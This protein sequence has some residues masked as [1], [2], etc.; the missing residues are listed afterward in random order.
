[1]TNDKRELAARYDAATIYFHWLT[2]VLVVGLWVIG[3]TAGW[4][5][6]GPQRATVWSVHVML[7]FAA[8]LVI[9]ARIVWRA[10]FGY[11]PPP[12]NAGLLHV[13]SEAVH[14]L[15]LGLLVTVL[16]TGIATASYRGFNIF[17]VWEVPQFGSGD[18]ATRRSLREW[19]EL[20]AHATMVVAGVHAAA[21]LVHQ[22]VWRDR[23]IDRMR[24]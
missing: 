3:M 7:G 6:R 20:A 4:F 12:A 10:A 17:G 5:P 13:A 19:H 14:Y 18:R 9:A 2:V 15:L 21:A 16:A 11:A 22:Y 24:L 8:T 1:M 23:L